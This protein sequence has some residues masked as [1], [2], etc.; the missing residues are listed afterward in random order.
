MQPKLYTK[1]MFT[2]LNMISFISNSPLAPSSHVNYDLRWFC[3]RLTGFFLD[4]ADNKIH[5]HGHN[6]LVSSLPVSLKTNS[7][8]HG[9]GSSLAVRWHGEYQHLG[10]ILMIGDQWSAKLIIS[11]I[12]SLMIFG[13]I[14][15]VTVAILMARFTR[16]LWP[17]KKLF[18]AKYWFV[19]GF[20]DDHRANCLITLYFSACRFI[21]TWWSQA[22]WP[23]W[24]HTLLFLCNLRDGQRCV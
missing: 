22:G 11:F 16:D 7:T 8:I 2:T 1:T 19:V 14:G 9:G 4:T 15:C 17:E 5:Y 21:D 24:P 12:A 23:S 6:T 13:W 18:G 10:H 3:Q 20:H